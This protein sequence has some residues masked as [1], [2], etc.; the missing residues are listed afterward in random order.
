VS[1][2]GWREKNRVSVRF[3]FYIVWLISGGVTLIS[4]CFLLCSQKI[5]PPTTRPKPAKP[6]TIPPAIAPAWLVDGFEVAVTVG[7]DEG[8]LDVEEPVVEV[9]VEVE[10]VVSNDIVDVLVLI[11]LLL[12]VIELMR[13]VLMTVELGTKV[14][15]N[16]AVVST[17]RTPV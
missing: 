11:T 10:V 17:S 13:G 5:A 7:G 2:F 15:V 9:E 8:E 1:D 6:P 3:G 16:K 14:L 4:L 12:L